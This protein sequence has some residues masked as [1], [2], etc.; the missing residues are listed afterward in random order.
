MFAKHRYPEQHGRRQSLKQALSHYSMSI[1]HRRDLPRTHV[2][3]L[4]TIEDLHPMVV[5]EVLSHWTH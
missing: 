4:D 5:N 1:R 3:A 2:L